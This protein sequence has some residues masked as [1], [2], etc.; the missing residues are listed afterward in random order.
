MKPLMHRSALLLTVVLA[1]LF[2][3]PVAWG[4]DIGARFPAG[5]IVDRE[6]AEAALR[7]VDAEAA[8]LEHEFA[9]REAECYRRFL[10]NRCREQVRDDREAAERELRRVRL[11][12][13]DTQRRL[14]AED[15]ARRRE[16][17][18]AKAAERDAVAVPA[19]SKT[20]RAAVE[21]RPTEPR[22]PRTSARTPQEEAAAAQARAAAEARQR[23]RVAE[24]ERRAAGSGANVRDYE[25]RQAEAAKAAAAKEAERRETEARRAER[26][27]KLEEA[28]ARREEIRQRAAEAAR[29]AGK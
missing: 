18:Q 22:E 29:A 24:A 17:E 8:R 2:S 20:P 3:L 6:Q 4:S 7:A 15:I 10:V 9:R 21:P 26:R 12:A 14:D 19:P 25:A 5:S 16:A 27:R 1:G 13:R 28:E 11:E 23:E